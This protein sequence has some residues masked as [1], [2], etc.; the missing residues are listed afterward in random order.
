MDLFLKCIAGVLIT[1]VLCLVMG[2]QV[3]DFSLLL[4]ITVCCMIGCAALTYLSPVISL[5]EKLEGLGNLD[6]E[7]VSVVIKA[8]GI[9]Y[10]GEISALVC[11]DA[12]NSAL[13]KTLQ[14]LTAAV[15]LCISIPLFQNLLEIIDKILV[16]L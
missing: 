13:G 9:G 3:K 4:T 1:A 2:N 12:G 10:L 6:R 8:V 5:F 14:F 16:S 11:A 15:M 7:L